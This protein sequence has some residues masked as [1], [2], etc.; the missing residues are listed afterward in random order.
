[1]SDVIRVVLADD[2][3]MMREGVRHVLAGTA[4]FQVVGEAASGRDAVE[5]AARTQPDVVLLDISMP[6]GT[7]LEILGELKRRAPATR[8][9]V[10]S[11]HD[12]T[13]Y[14]LESVR[15]GAA[16]YLRKDTTPD[17]LRA[18][19]RA[20]A[21]GN[22]WFSP[23]VARHLAAAIRDEPAGPPAAPVPAAAP[24][25]SAGPLTAREREVLSCV[26]RG[27]TNKEA[28]GELGI[29]IRTVE[30]HR[31]NLMRKLGIHTVAGLTRYALEAGLIES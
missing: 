31:D 4:G 13:E 11:V 22:G 21:A 6:H 17:N 7:G 20:I 1:M 5:T 24:Q 16:G 26:A 14:V 30:T 10:L 28:A 12:D 8:V 3:A 23:E 19:V 18:A 2:H 29:S 27:L 25:P 15:A 9:L